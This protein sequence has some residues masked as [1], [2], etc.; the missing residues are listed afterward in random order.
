MQV[1]L[2]LD[3]RNPP[4]W[5][6]PWAEVYETA[7]HRI[8]KAERLGLDSIWLTEHHFFE[9]GYLSQPMTFAAA[10]AVRTSRVRLGTAVFLAP[11]R[12]AADIAEQTA[13]VDILSN[14][15]LDLGL[16]AGYRLPE[17]EAYGVDVK[18]RFKLLEQRVQ[19]I[20]E[21]WSSGKVVPPPIQDDVPI[22]IGANGP[23]GGRIAGRLGAGLIWADHDI[24]AV[25]RETLER[26]GHDPGSARIS[27]LANM[28]I[29]DDPEAAWQRIAPHLG[30]QWQTYAFYG[31]EGTGTLSEPALQSLDSV[32]FDPNSIRSKG[33]AM[34]PPSFDVVT[35][36][37]AIARL[38]QWHSGLPTKTVFFWDSIAGMPNDLADRHLELLASE[39]APVMRSHA[40]DG[41]SI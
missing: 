25:Y 19:Q 10:I 33:P 16:G 23:G 15:R 35:P 32:G 39:V 34:N 29:A 21:L 17:F 13:I 6:R 4:R 12:S 3:M 28:I 1:G 2:Y 7:L 22:W 27:C 9:D 36:E 11:L 20:R 5:K 40:L 26:S 30:H 18:Q 8:E 38:T 31:Q 24:Y 41:A 14:G 37:D